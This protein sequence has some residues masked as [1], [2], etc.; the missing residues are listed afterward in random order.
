MYPLQAPCYR[1]TPGQ[2]SFITFLVGL[3]AQLKGRSTHI[4]PTPALL[5]V[6]PQPRRCP[7]RG[8]RAGRV[9]VQATE[10][11]SV[12][13]HA[14]LSAECRPR[15]DPLQPTSTLNFS[16]FAMWCCWPLAAPHLVAENAPL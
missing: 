10:G 8:R 2:S 5:S 12:L 11:L 3:G 6:S 15:T 14:R 1:A 16:A 4:L 9:V 7:L 13:G